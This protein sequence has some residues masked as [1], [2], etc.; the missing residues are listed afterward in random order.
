MLDSARGGKKMPEKNLIVLGGTT[1]S[2]T[3][4]LESLSSESGKRRPPD[5][6]K[7]TPPVANRFALGYTYMDVLDEDQDGTWPLSKEHFEL[8]MI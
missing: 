3:A 4:F 2:Q 1:E 5:R 6:K 8:D 7:R